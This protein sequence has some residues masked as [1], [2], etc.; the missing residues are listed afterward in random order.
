MGRSSSPLSRFL[1]L[2]KNHPKV[3]PLHCYLSLGNLEIKFI[4]CVQGINFSGRW[5][6]LEEEEVEEEEEEGEG[7]SQ[8]RVGGTERGEGGTKNKFYWTRCKQ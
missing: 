5:K 2:K 7:G 8:E 4:G 6:H 1:F 3:L